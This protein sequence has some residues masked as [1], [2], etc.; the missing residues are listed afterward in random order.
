MIKILVQ[1]G[2]G[3]VQ[4]FSIALSCFYLVLGTLLTMNLPSDETPWE[5][6]RMGRRYWQWSF[7]VLQRKGPGQKFLAEVVATKNKN[8]MTRL[9]CNW[10]FN[11]TFSKHG[12]HFLMTLIFVATKNLRAVRKPNLEHWIV[13]ID[14]ANFYTVEIL[15]NE[16]LNNVNI[17]ITNFYL[18]VI[19]MPYS[20][21]SLVFKWHLNTG[22]FGDRKT[23]DHL[24]RKR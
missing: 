13:K 10:H 1:K 18:F 17:W 20:N 2:A 8:W 6:G 16:H 21:G 3:V 12:G 24:K 19:Q 11:K 14:S 22:P 15:K 9:K 23:F 4:I 7:L 5:W